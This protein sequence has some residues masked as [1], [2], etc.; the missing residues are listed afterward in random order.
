MSHQAPYGRRFGEYV[1][2]I[3]RMLSLG[4]QIF[5]AGF[6]ADQNWTPLEALEM[7]V[8]QPGL[9]SPISTAPLGTRKRAAKNI[10]GDF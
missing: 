10:L 6:Q 5:E 7:S 1:L 4:K 3:Q 2:K 9:Q 8:Q